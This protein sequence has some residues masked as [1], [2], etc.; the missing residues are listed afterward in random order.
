MPN[1]SCDFCS[2]SY[3]INPSIGYFKLTSYMRT[4]LKLLDSRADFICGFHFTESDFQANG[5]L[6]PRAIP[7]FFPSRSNMIHDHPYH[8]RE[9]EP[10]LPETALPP[11]P[12]NEDDDIGRELLLNTRRLAI[13]YFV[14]C[15]DS[16]TL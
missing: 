5:R 4:S 13:Y 3:R 14:F 12:E 7:S 16:G 1:R 6:L 11:Q 10:A 15:L 2:N 9:K 8:K